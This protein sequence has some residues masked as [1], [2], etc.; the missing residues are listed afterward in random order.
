VILFVTEKTVPT[1]GKGVLSKGQTV[2]LATGNPGKVRELQV[3]FADRDLI[4]QS[5]KELG[6]SSVAETGT[7]FIENAIIKARHAAAE[8]GLPALADDSGLMVRALH[9]APGIYSARYGGE[10][11]TDTQ[12]IEKLLC[13]LAATGNPDRTACFCCALAYFRHADDPAPLIAFGQWWGS[14]LEKPVGEDGFG[15][16]PIFW[17]P[18]HECSAAQLDTEEK[19]HISHRGIAMQAFMQQLG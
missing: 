17:V 6:V 10:N 3:Y 15:Y 18:T 13:E 14:I 2:V 7:T 5:Q 9:D 12:R 16:D 4:F 11:A 19:N 8:T 1:L